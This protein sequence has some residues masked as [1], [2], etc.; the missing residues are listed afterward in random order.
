MELYEGMEGGIMMT[1]SEAIKAIQDNYP[2]CSGYTMLREAL[3][4]AIDL[5][6]TKEAE[7]S[8]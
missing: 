4:M 6:K 5:L 7:G 3:D 2:N 1:Y 8:E